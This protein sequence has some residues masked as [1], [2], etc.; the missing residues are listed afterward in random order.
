MVTGGRVGSQGHT[1]CYEIDRL[2]VPDHGSKF[3][4]LLGTEGKQKHLGNL[5][6]YFCV[7]FF[8][9]LR[10]QEG[11]R[12]REMEIFCLRSHSQTPAVARNPEPN[13]MA[14]MDGRDPSP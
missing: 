10:N 3:T 6:A 12:N 13:P 8:E 4:E 5:N 14:H 7:L 9:K 2:T 11:D 1:L